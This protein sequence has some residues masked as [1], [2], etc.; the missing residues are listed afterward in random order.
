MLFVAVIDIIF[1]L[2]RRDRQEHKFSRRY[3]E[4]YFP[5]EEQLK[6]SLSRLAAIQWESYKIMKYLH[7]QKNTLYALVFNNSINLSFGY[8]VLR[9]SRSDCI[10]LL[11]AAFM[12]D[13]SMTSQPPIC[14][15]ILMYY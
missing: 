4:F 3:F 7:W 12:N 1:C 14:Y 13:F 10:C 6:R 2:T 5:T 15:I 9:F 11:C 8:K